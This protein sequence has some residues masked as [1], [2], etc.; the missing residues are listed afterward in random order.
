MKKAGRINRRW[1]LWLPLLAVGLWLALFGDKSPAGDG[2]PG[3][4]VRAVVDRARTATAVTSAVSEDPVVALVPRGT[5]VPSPAAEA[6]AAPDPFSARTWTP[7]PAPPPPEAAPPPMAPPLPFAF[8]GKKVEGDAWEV[9]LSI[10]SR[11]LIVREGQVIDNSYRVDRIAPPTLGF[12]YLPLQQV[13][14]LAIG[15]AR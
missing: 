5:L 3:D 4:P 13:Q 14:S 11:T 15:E 7:P 8:L 1:W 12:T 6:R 9:Y 10:G 2:Q